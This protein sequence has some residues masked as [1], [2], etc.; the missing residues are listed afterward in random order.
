[1]DS[2]GL[3]RRFLVVAPNWIGDALMSLPLLAAIKR[4]WPT[5]SVSVLAP[6]SVARVLARSGLIDEAIETTW[7]HGGLQLRGRLE[8]AAALRPR[9]F[10]SAVILPNSFKSALV[11]LFAG[12]PNRV[13]YVGEARRLILSNST[14]NP[15]QR[16]PMVAQYLGLAALIGANRNGDLAEPARLAVTSAEITAVFQRFGLVTGQKTVVL[17][18]GAEYGPAKRWPAQHFFKTRGIDPCRLPGSSAGG[19]GFRRRCRHCSC[20]RERLYRSNR[21]NR[22]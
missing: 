2:A 11:P 17:C 18:P 13:G 12:I 8:L 20:D 14:T 16:S 21:F 15:Q 5:A 19:G 7:R 4:S 9:K 10:D 3:C 1:M 22:R 6:A